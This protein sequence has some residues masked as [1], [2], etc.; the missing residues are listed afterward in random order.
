VG[1]HGEAGSSRDP[2]GGQ[3]TAEI[4]VSDWV[5]GEVFI[6]VKITGDNSRSLGWSNFAVLQVVAP[7]PV[8]ASLKAGN[9]PAGVQLSWQSGAASHRI[10]RAKGDE[11][12]EQV[13]TTPQSPWVDPGAVPGVEYRYRVQAVNPAGDKEAESLISDAVVIMARDVAPP[14][15][16]VAVRAIA[17]LGTIEI[18]WDAN[19]EADIAGYRLFRSAGGDWTRVGGDLNAPAFTDRDV[20]SGKAYR[21]TVAAFDAN[22]NES[23]RSAPVEIT[24]P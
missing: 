1:C 14:A 10:L 15:T 18:A 20:Q 19:R 12:P 23:G 22:G 13:A 9:V 21:Y 7:V 6:A 8:P 16:P 4:P 24:A 2:I 17:G 5:G 3:V 11:P